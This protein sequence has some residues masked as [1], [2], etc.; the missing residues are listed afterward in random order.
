[1]PEAADEAVGNLAADSLAMVDEEGMILIV[2]PFILGQVFGEKRLEGGVA[3]GFGGQAEAAED[4]PGVGVDDKDRPLGGVEDYGVRGLRADAVNGKELL[5]KGG[6]IK[7]K[8]RPQVAAVSGVESVSEGL[9][10]YRLCIVIAGGADKVGQPI[11]REIMKRNRG[12]CACRLEV[13]NSLLNIGPRRRLGEDGPHD[14]LKEFVC[15]PPMLRT[16]AGEEAMINLQQK[17]PYGSHSS[18]LVQSATL[19]SE[20]ESRR[21]RYGLMSITGVPSMAS[22]PTTLS[23][24]PLRSSS[25]TTLNPRAL[26]R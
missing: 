13:G 2:Q 22:S 11:E 15:G 26:G 6:G 17:F 23:M 24:F 12:Q 1:M 19:T 5:A 25:L 8:K 3:I 10:L 18:F 21:G 9:K 20:G 7:G 14:D 16:I 4:A